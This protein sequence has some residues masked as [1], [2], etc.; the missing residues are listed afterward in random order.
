MKIFILYI[1][2]D[3]S[4]AIYMSKNKS[5]CEAEKKRLIKKGITCRMWIQSYD[6]SKQDSFEL[7]C[8]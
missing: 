4:T 1:L 2:S 8:D 3:Y 6:F 5:D 7:H